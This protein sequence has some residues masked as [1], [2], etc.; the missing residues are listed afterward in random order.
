MRKKNQKMFNVLTTRNFTENNSVFVK[1]YKNLQ[2]K[3]YLKTG[4]LTF[5][6]K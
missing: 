6:L 4:L 2:S 5:Y 3:A 1:V